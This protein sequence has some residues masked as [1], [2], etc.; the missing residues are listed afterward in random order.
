MWVNPRGRNRQLGL[1]GAW[2]GDTRPSPQGLESEAKEQRMQAVS[3]S[4]TSKTPEQ[5]HSH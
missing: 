1:D 3:H 2:E 4:H 5:S